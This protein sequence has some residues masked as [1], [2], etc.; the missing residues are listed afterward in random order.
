MA[1]VRRV[2]SE[3]LTSDSCTLGRAQKSKSLYFEV[4]KKMGKERM[5]YKWLNTYA[6]CY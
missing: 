4:N 1:G 3:N 6:F 2:W 5:E